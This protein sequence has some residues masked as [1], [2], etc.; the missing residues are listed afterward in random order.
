VAGQPLGLD[1]VRER[2]RSDYDIEEKDLPSLRTLQRWAS[3]D[4]AEIPVH[5]SG[6]RNWVVYETDLGIVAAK[7]RQK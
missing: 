1:Q 2:L 3:A 5:R 6:K 4:P 7:V